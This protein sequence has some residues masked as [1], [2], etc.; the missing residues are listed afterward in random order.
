M[1][2]QCVETYFKVVAISAFSFSLPLIAQ[3]QNGWQLDS[4]STNSSGSKSNVQQVYEV[5]RTMFD[6]WN[7]HDLEK[8]LEGYSKSPELL[9]VIDAEEFNGWQQLHDYYASAYPDRDLMGFIE[10][11]RI[12]VKLLKPDFALALTRWSVSFP[13]AKRPVVAK[14]T[15]NLQNVNRAWKIVESHTSTSDL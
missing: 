8:Y 9:V 11:T 14:T 3:E 2:P 6:R 1:F 13:T 7:A 5:L 15:M 4:L 10:P 12:Q